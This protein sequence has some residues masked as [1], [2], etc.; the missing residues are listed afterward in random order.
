M[1]YKDLTDVEIHN[2]GEEV[3]VCEDE[4]C[5]DKNIK[6]YN[7]NGKVIQRQLKKVFTRY[8]ITLIELNA[9]K[10]DNSLVLPK[11]NPSYYVISDGTID[12]F[13]ENEIVETSRGLL[14]IKFFSGY[15][16]RIC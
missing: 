14:S 12:P 11:F 4:D 13:R 6:S 16:G 1:V 15:V 9:V 3:R 7:E 10:F 5:A 8:G 2:L